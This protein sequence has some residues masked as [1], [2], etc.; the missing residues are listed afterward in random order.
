[1]AIQPENESPKTGLQKFKTFVDQILH[2]FGK[3]VRKAPV[4]FLEKVWEFF[5]SLFSAAIAALFI[6]TF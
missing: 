1:M 3:K 2:P 5:R 4:T 6:I